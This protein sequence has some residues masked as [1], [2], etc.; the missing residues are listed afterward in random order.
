MRLRGATV[1]REVIEQRIERVA[2]R[3]YLVARGRQAVAA[4]IDSQQIVSLGIQ[5]S[6]TIRMLGHCAVIRVSSHDGV[7]YIHG[8][9]AIEDATAVA[10]AR[11]I[12]IRDILAECDV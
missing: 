4:R 7:L 10:A 2:G 12:V 5:C 1:I 9:G 6:R 8:S 11:A 3:S